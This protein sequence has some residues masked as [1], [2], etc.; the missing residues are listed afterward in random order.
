MGRPLDS[1]EL[2]AV[3]A[4]THR[5]QRVE[6]G[7]WRSSDRWAL[8]S[9][10]RLVPYLRPLCR[11]APLNDPPPFDPC[12][13][14]WRPRPE[15]WGKR[16]RVMR[17]IAVPPRTRW[18]G[19]VEVANPPRERIW[20]EDDPERAKRSRRLSIALRRLHEDKNALALPPLS[21]E[22]GSVSRR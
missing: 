3:Q 22:P 5:I 2:L 12:K 19:P 8:M 7:R 6:A 1:Q 18:N 4:A 20:R 16:G 17:F 13:D 10:G 11:S 15:M 21:S 9:N 14:I